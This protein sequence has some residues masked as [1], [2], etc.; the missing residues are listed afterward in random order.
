MFCAMAA[1]TGPGFGR[2]LPMPLLI[3]FAGETAVAASLVFPVWGIFS[4]RRRLGRVH[5]AWGWG[6]AAILGGQIL[7]ELVSHTT[8]GLPLYNWVAA[9]SPGA[10]IS[11]TAYP[12]APLA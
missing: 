12:A 3:P 11:P 10:L 1:L 7:A 8:L 2:L 6:L 4:D 9:G 5:P